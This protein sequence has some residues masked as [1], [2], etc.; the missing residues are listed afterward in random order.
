[1][2]FQK[3]VKVM[4]VIKVIKVKITPKHTRADIIMNLWAITLTSH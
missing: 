4:K 1:M 2:H 3:T